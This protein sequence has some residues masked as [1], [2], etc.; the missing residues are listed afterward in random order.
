MRKPADVVVVACRILRHIPQKPWNICADCEAEWRRI[1][2]K[3]AKHAKETRGELSATVITYT[4][5]GLF[6]WTVALISPA[7]ALAGLVGMLVAKAVGEFRH[8]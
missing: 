8:R 2:E 7:A 6:L 3:H 4:V 5:V 1:T